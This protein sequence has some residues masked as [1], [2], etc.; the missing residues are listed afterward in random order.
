[1]T[2]SILSF[3]SVFLFGIE[4]EDIEI[5]D[6]RTT[7][8]V[9]YVFDET[10]SL[11]RNPD[12]KGIKDNDF[13][14][15]LNKNSI[16]LSGVYRI[17]FGG[18]WTKFPV[19]IGETIAIH[20]TDESLNLEYRRWEV[21]RDNRSIKFKV[22]R[23]RRRGA[24]RRRGSN[25]QLEDQFGPDA[26]LAR[27]YGFSFEGSYY[28]LPRPVIFLVHGTGIAATEAGGANP[29]VS[30][31]PRI[32]ELTGLVAAGFDFA[33]DVRVWFYDKA[34]YT[35]RMDVETGMFE[36]VL[37]QAELGGGPGG[38][39]AAGMSAR[40]MSARGMSARGMSARGMSARGMSARGG[41]NS[42]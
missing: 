28:N 34:D 42:D 24:R 39:E 3:S 17:N 4:I 31:A 38:M 18:R 5:S 23:D 12:I 40:G 13:V 36:D 14:L 37:L 33:D 2:E 20:N 21:V 1:M 30:R 22:D 32:P 25:R 8:R 35:V 11:S 41:N 27:V 26:R 16:R 10:V 6:R 9:R 15:V 29:H 19:E 7:W